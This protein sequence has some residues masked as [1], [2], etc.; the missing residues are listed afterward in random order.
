[1]F[2]IWLTVGFFEIEPNYDSVNDPQFTRPYFVD[3]AHPDGYRYGIEMGSDL[4]RVKRHRAF[5]IVD[6][7]IPVAF[8]RGVN[9]NVDDAILLRRYLE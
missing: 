7:S 1:V 6:R 9:H 8:E 4:G 3:A 2:A 5:F